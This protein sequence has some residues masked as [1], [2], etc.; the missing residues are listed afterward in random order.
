MLEEILNSK[1]RVRILQ[2]L[3][4]RPDWIFSESEISRELE[5]AKA[6][7][8][9]NI[10]PLV[11]YNVIRRF[12]KGKSVVYQI[13]EKNYLVKELLKPLFLKEV[14]L[15]IEAAEDFCKQVEGLIKIGIVFGSAA[16]GKMKPMSDIDLALVT[17]VPDELESKVDKL[18]TEFLNGRGIIISTHILD[19]KN[20]KKRVEAKD[21]YIIEI[22]NGKVVFGD[23]EEVL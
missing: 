2:L 4:T 10:K 1:P 14:R 6:T 13:N 11:D 22:T 12:K 20:F 7:I 16:Q 17:D 15:P 9:R 19:S 5:I 23:L 8:Y 3:I 18:K 21:P